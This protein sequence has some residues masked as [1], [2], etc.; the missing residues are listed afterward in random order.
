MPVETQASSLLSAVDEA[1][2][3]LVSRSIA[4]NLLEIPT[5]TLYAEMI[6]VQKT[7]EYV[8]SALE[9]AKMELAKGR[10]KLAHF[11]ECCNTI[12][13]QYAQDES[14]TMY[15]E[16]LNSMLPDL[17]RQL[18]QDE[19]R[20]LLR[21]MGL[22]RWIEEN[23]KQREIVHG[24]LRHC[25]ERSVSKCEKEVSDLTAKVDSLRQKPQDLDDRAAVL[26]ACKVLRSEA[27]RAAAQALHQEMLQRQRDYSEEQAGAAVG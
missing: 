3:S 18:S 1:S 10:S 8:L 22:A 14:L 2:S 4:L 27:G 12:V 19:S 25:T 24:E 9:D 7:R 5:A 17:G 11:R 6:A 13:E 21:N 26:Q 16:S 23:K 20:P 15:D